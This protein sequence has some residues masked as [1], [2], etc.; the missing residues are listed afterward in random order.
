[1]AIQRY[2]LTILP[3][4]ALAD[5]VQRLR[6][7]LHPR[8]GSFSGRHTPPHITLCFLDLPEHHAPAIV[9]AIERGTAGLHGFTLHY[10]GITH[11]ADRRTIY[12]DPVDKDAIAAVREPVV[13]ALL[14]DE[15]WR[16][17]LRVTD[18]PH[19]TIAAGL[20]PARFSEAWAMLAP[21]TCTSVQEVH[22]L[23]LLSRP[24]QPGTRYAHRRAFPLH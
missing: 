22:E 7:M 8:I 1:M 21:H 12:I 10:R 19:L 15:Q 14:A 9:A 13:H 17:A 16:A 5:E 2:L 3:H 4:Q 18:H 11:F 6:A 24:L 23:V 20:K